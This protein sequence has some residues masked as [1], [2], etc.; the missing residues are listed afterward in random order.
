M[1]AA[2]PG[3]VGMPSV[4]LLAE[5]SGQVRQGGKQRHFH[6]ALSGQALQHGGKPKCDSVVSSHGKEIAEGEQN[7]V[8]VTQSLPNAVGANV[9]F[10]LFLP[11]KLRDDPLAF[12]GGEPIRLP[13]P[14]RQVN[15]SD[16]TQEDRWDSFKDE[17]PPPASQT[18][19]GKSKQQA[20]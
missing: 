5:K 10:R 2:F 20:R 11:L 15:Q 6:V 3:A 9:L 17:E 13:W 19:P 8:A 14:V 12:F 16:Q 18:K 1:P 7:N 4:Q